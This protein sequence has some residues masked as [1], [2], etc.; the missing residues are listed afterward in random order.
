MSIQPIKCKNIESNQTLI[1]QD[2]EKF[3]KN[4]ENNANLFVKFENYSG[5]WG[6]FEL[7]DEAKDKNSVISNI[8]LSVERGQLLGIIGK[9]GSGKSSILHAILGEIPS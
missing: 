8:N 1:Q 4:C 3:I 6:E 9:V 2:R 7:I 5:Y